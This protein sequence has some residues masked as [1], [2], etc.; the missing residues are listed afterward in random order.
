VEKIIS[1]AKRLY[2]KSKGDKVQLEVIM[3]R[4]RGRFVQYLQGRV[5]LTLK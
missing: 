1:A 4:Q 5:E 3:P 2:G